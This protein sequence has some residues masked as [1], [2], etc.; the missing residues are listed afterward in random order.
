MKTKLLPESY[1]RR[2]RCGQTKSYFQKGS[3]GFIPA[4][5]CDNMRINA[6][7]PD[8]DSGGSPESRRLQR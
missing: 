3:D 7:S 8:I 2:T 4:G 5:R 1:F 6:Q